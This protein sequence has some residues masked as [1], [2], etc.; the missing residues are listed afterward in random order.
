MS[1]EILL[2]KKP[3]L[4]YCAW[5]SVETSEIFYDFAKKN[6][7]PFVLDV[8][9][10]WPDV[11]Y[12]R[13]GSKIN[14]KSVPRFLT[15]YERIL[16][17]C[18][19]N[20]TSVVTISSSFLE[21]IYQRSGRL[22]NPDDIVCPLSCEDLSVIS[23]NKDILVDYWNKKNVFQ[24]DSI[25][26]IVMIGTLIPQDAFLRFIEAI[27]D[28]K[29]PPNIQFVICG[30]GQLEKYLKNIKS[31]KIIYAGYVGR[32]QLAY[33]LNISDIGLLP[34]DPTEDFLM[35][36][37]NKIGEYLS[38][39]LHILTNLKGEISKLLDGSGVITYFDSDNK[40]NIVECLVCLYKKKSQLSNLKSLSRKIYL[41]ELNAKINYSSLVNELESIVIKFSEVA[42]NES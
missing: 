29:T 9:D 34:Y 18:F 41:N 35:S 15:N 10:Q 8:R 11:I 12:R 27:L 38:G 37:P 1:K 36:V 13:L 40:Q 7:I 31:K 28:D 22:Q 14:V 24:S 6:K 33:L 32:E 25:L 42:D 20:S 4:I 3:D 21:W 2:R 5:P 16:K 30:T 39:G 19:I 26:R 23:S 17:K